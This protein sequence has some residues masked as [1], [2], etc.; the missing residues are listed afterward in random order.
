MEQN[1]LISG[2]YTIS[3]VFLQL[4]VEQYKWKHIPVKA[5]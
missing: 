4:S 2:A 5:I 3:G 1:S